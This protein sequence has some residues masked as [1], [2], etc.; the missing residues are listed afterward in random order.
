MDDNQIK[1]KAL[2]LTT[3]EYIAKPTRDLTWLEPRDQQE[4]CRMLD[5]LDAAL[6]GADQMAGA[7]GQTTIDY[8]G[9]INWLR[10]HLRAEREVLIAE[11]EAAG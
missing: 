11:L 2:G 3:P 8:A 6:A 10:V 4:R 9:H 5:R 7:L 1:W